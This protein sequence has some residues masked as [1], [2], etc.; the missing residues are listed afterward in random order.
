MAQE[1]GRRKAPRRVAP[2][3]VDEGR[4]LQGGWCQAIGV[5][6]TVTHS[7]VEYLEVAIWMSITKRHQAAR[8]VFLASTEEVARRRAA[9]P[10]TGSASSRWLAP[11]SEVAPI[12]SRST[13]LPW[14]HR[15][16]IE[17]AL[18]CQGWPDMVLMK[19]CWKMVVTQVYWMNYRDVL[20][21][22]MTDM[23][24]TQDLKSVKHTLH[25]LQGYMDYV[26]IADVNALEP[27]NTLQHTL[28]AQILECVEEVN[29]LTAQIEAKTLEALQD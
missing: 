7:E 29:A 26:N 17:K 2:R 11:D 6:S 9:A 14:E 10:A 15:K 27:C 18:E 19:T 4:L 13:S 25:N 8:P 28:K 12:L 5:R 23:Q 1:S 3:R 16:S 24:D 21:L 20:H 22:T